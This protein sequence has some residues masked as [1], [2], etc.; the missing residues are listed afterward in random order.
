MKLKIAYYGTPDFSAAFLKKILDD[1]SLPIKVVAVITQPDKPAGRKQILTPSPV[2]MLAQKANLPVL[3]TDEPG[4]DIDLALLYA[5]GE[6]I[7][8]EVLSRPH[9]G[10]WNIHPS[11]LPDYRGAAP[12][13]YPL[14]LGDSQT[15]VTLMQMDKDLDH[16]RIIA[17]KTLPILANETRPELEKKLTAHGYVL[18]KEKITAVAGWP[19]GR[20]IQTKPQN[21]TLATFTGRL[22]K[23]DGFISWPALQKSIANKPLE[24]DELPPIL[25]NFYQNNKIAIAARA[26]SSLLAYQINSARTVYDLFRGLSPWPGLW[27]TVLMNGTKK[28][29]KIIGMT[30]G[31]IK[32]VQLD[33][34]KP[35]D[36]VTFQQA[37]HLF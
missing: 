32:T 3:K 24:K 35:V 12:M 33:G 9:L 6:M 20:S 19:A 5:Y 36:F 37:Y 26:Q 18:F 11:R 13:A 1:V 27:T 8:D 34:K 2:K 22:T 25:N 15:G 4:P 21:H 10:F 14:F 16:G 29:L 7:P 17:Q 30:A 23:Q 31:T 28:R